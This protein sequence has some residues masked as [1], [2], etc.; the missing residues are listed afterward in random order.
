MAVKG[1]L[2]ENKYYIF[3]M[4]TTIIYVIKIKQIV[5]Y[6]ITDN[7]VLNVRSSG[8]SGYMEPQDPCFQVVTFE[9]NLTKDTVSVEKHLLKLDDPHLST[10]C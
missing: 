3:H 4:T 8:V 5:K 9:E 7:N 6:C 1:T 10:D 2:E